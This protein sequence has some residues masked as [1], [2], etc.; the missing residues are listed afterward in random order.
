M[1]VP[2]KKLYLLL[3]DKDADEALRALRALGVVHVENNR[4]PKGEEINLLS[5]R[6]ALVDKAIE[7]IS[8][9]EF[10]AA[11]VPEKEVGGW[12]PVA[13]HIVDRKKHLDHLAE[14]S[15]A[16]KAKISQWEEWGDFNPGDVQLLKEKNVGMRFYRIP[17]GDFKKISDG[18]LVKEISRVKGV[19]N[20]IIISGEAPAVPFKELELPKSGLGQMRQRLQ[21]DLK[22]AE[23]IKNEL[24]SL[25]GYLSG[26]RR[27][28]SLLEKDREFL[29]VLKG[30][31]QEGS[32]AYL[33][34]YVPFDK[35]ELVKSAATANRWGIKVGDPGEDDR[36]PTLLRNP[37]WVSIIAPMFELIQVAPGYREL[38]ISLLF[39]FFLSLF[40]G[41]LIGDAGYG[42]VY[43]LVTLF[44]HHKLRSKVKNKSIF[45]LSY[46]FS[47]CA[48]IWGVLSATFFGADWLPRW[49]HPLVPALR[50]PK[51]VQMLC[52]FIGAFHLSLGHA[53]R[54]VKKAPD[55]RFLTEI[56]WIMILWGAFFLAKTLVLGDTFPF[57]GKWLFS[58][59]GTMVVFFTAPAKNILKSV[60]PGI[61]NLLL[62]LVNNFT[63]VVS[64]IRLFAVGL[65][66]VAVADAFNNMA[67]TVGFNNILTA[68]VALLII[69]V[70][71][72]LNL[73]L[74][75]MSVLV[76]GV[77]L[78]VL[79]FCSHVDVKWSGFN[80][81]PLRE[82]KAVK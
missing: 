13:R 66:T 48:I 82:E 67:A 45:L 52:F 70:G 71:H 14:F 49:I 7:I 51:D 43:L 76:H 80:Y 65:A 21:E 81:S 8:D 61:G 35:V 18:L 4:P 77:R 37:R 19:V 36:V 38:D 47:S 28:R 20:C 34:G 40:F 79:E 53:W 15:L 6:I 75:P 78:N 69:L 23:G 10:H 64:Y 58:L 72:T 41:I 74:G 68:I 26:L 63:D 50:D 22:I 55:L 3:L 44:F 60:G 2:M 11:S 5:E 31:G 12:E 62:N 24:K 27:Q 25:S 17:A 29:E 9:P 33:T 54:A 59:G 42:L 46:I 1:I 16:L 56:G 57:F 32:L 39:L 73:I 30:M